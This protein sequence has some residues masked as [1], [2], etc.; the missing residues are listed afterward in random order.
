MRSELVTWSISAWQVLQGNFLW[1]GWNLF[2]GFIPLVL[3]VWLFRRNHLSLPQDASQTRRQSQIH[4]IFWW[5]GCLIFIAFL[6]NAPYVLTDVIHLIG[7]IRT[8]YY[9]VWLVTLALIPQYLLFIGAGFQAYVISVI[10]LG[11]YLRRQGLGRFI[12]PVEF[13]IHTLSAIGIY[14]GRFLRFNSWDLVTQLDT[15]AA[16]ITENLTSKGTI[17]IISVTFV[18]ITGLYGLM[19]WVT[20]AVAAYRPTSDNG[21]LPPQPKVHNSE[22]QHYR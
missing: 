7:D 22:L 16:G 21:S 19:K 11:Y 12:L 4:K 5:I 9:S 10:N 14:L 1:M 2:L 13:F 17:L 20:L 3:S 6:P 18:V 8:H 15:V